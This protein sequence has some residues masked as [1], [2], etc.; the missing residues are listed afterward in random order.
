MN[1]RRT[2]FEIYWEILV[3]CKTPRSFTAIV[4]RCDLNSKTGQ[5][6]LEFLGKKGYLSMVV[7]GEKT[8]Y[9]STKGAGDYITLFSSLYQKLFDSEPGF[10]L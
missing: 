4:N 8:R 7:D 5:E 3:Y 9:V 10:R 2:V 6:Y 1:G